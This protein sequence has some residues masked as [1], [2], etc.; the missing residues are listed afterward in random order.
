MDDDTTVIPFHQP[1]SITDP[2][3]EIA[4]EGA[5]GNGGAK[6]DH[7]NGGVGSLRAE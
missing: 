3:T 6:V 7:G 5:R 4:R 1:G 2:L